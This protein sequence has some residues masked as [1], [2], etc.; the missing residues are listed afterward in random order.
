VQNF[1]RDYL[2][3]FGGGSRYEMLRFQDSPYKSPCS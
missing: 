3:L 2:L 1:R